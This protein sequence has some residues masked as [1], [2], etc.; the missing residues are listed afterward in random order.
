MKTR[1]SADPDLSPAGP[2][3][4]D[5]AEPDAAE[6]TAAAPDA[7]EDIA[8]ESAQAA[9]AEPESA[10]D[11]A[12][13]PEKAAAEKRARAAEKAAPA[14]PRREIRLRAPGP[15]SRRLTVALLV[16][17]FLAAVATA[18]IQWRSASDLAAQDRVEQQVRT[19]SAEFAQALM[20]YKH[21]EMS[22]AQDRILALSS[23]D[24]GSTY[25]TAFA[26]LS[27]IITKYQADATVTI[28]DIYLSELDGQ[29]AKTLVVLDTE[30]TSTLG[31]RRVRGSK[32]LLELVKEKGTWRVDSMITLPADEDTLTDPEGNVTSTS[33]SDT[34]LTDTTKT[35]DEKE[36]P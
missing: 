1:T 2:A 31:V 13:A 11:V 9:P 17:V 7:A 29:L 30:V 32:L 4:A 5:S 36:T 22:S 21:T 15:P 3:P 25:D 26:P 34:A 19:R 23:A 35:D 33:D 28:R 27:E 10:A 6:E 18:G 20:A 12:A 8:E 16:L 14:K 24:F